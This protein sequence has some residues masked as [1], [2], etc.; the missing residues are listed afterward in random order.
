MIY[1]KWSVSIESMF[2][3][4]F[5]LYL[6]I[7][8]LM[9]YTTLCIYCISPFTFIQHSSDFFSSWVCFWC[10]FHV[11]SYGKS[12]HLYNTAACQPNDTLVLS[13]YSP[14]MSCRF[15]LWWH[16]SADPGDTAPHLNA[17][18]DGKLNSLTWW[19]I[20]WSMQGRVLHKG[21]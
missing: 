7:Y 14:E 21:S 6:S 20:G 15:R 1:I 4:L 16:R 12:L 18:L 19:L 8:F 9:F 11:Y 10:I 3:V 13:L 17:H 2:F 5:T